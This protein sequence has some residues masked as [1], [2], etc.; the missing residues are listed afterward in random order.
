[1]IK[2]LVPVDG[3]AYAERAVH[4][5]IKLVCDKEP[6]E[7]HLVNV[8]T[9]IDAWEVKRFLTDEEITKAQRSEGASDL[10]SAEALLDAAGLSYTPHIEVGPIAPTIARLATELS[11]DAIVMGTHGRG[12]LASLV[13]GSIATKV[14]HL[15]TIPVTLVK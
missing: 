9:P 6:V 7:I 14:I 15:V 8:R 2:F 5:L 3:S 1:M 12:G 10:K 13:L 4:H 11:C